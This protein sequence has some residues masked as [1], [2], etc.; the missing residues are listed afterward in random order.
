MVDEVYIKST[1]TYH[2]GTLFGYSADQPGVL[3]RTM[4]ALMVNC[5]FSGPEFLVKLIPISCLD[6]EFLFKQCKPIIEMI[7]KHPNLKLK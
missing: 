6:S 7:N 1:L 2:G 5:L 4:L 3:A